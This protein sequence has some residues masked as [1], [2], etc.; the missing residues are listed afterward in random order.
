MEGDGAHFR[1]WIEPSSWLP[2]LSYFLAG[3]GR[4]M[5]SEST[6]AIMAS[7]ATAGEYR[8]W[9]YGVGKLVPAPQTAD[10]MPQVGRF[11]PCRYSTT[12]E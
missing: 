11:L 4:R 8:R 2:L 6:K 7:V 5:I 1:R 9:R 12:R 3:T 10:V